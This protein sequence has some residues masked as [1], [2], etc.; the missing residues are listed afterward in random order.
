MIAYKVVVKG[1]KGDL[2]SFM[3][4]GRLIQVYKPN[5]RVTARVGGF[6]CFGAK[7]AAKAFMRNKVFTKVELWKVE[8]SGG[9]RLPDR[10]LVT[11][12]NVR[13]AKLLW[14]NQGGF[15]QL[16][17]WWPDGTVAYKHV[18]LLEKVS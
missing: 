18:T 4:I 13:N 14:S 7:K 17:G 2:I 3:A 8:V 16:V 6:L 12:C 10:K 5:E 9:V 11:G 15:N 1:N